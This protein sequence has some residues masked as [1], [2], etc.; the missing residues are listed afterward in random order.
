MPGAK[1]IYKK[2]T[3]NYIMTFIAIIRFRGIGK[4][5]SMIVPLKEKEP[6]PQRSN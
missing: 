2:Y 1:K 5:T 6:A 3:V 4:K